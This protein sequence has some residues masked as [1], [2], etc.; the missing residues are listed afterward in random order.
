MGYAETG[1]GRNVYEIVDVDSALS[2]RRD[3]ARIF[4]CCM[5]RRIVRDLIRRRKVQL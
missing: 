5:V 2:P 4:C 3:I 1:K